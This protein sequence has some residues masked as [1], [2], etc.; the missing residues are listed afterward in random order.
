MTA[1]E[2]PRLNGAELKPFE[3]TLQELRAV[4]TGEIAQ[5]MEQCIKE[6]ILPQDQVALCEDAAQFTL[7]I[8]VLNIARLRGQEVNK[9]TL[10]AAYWRLEKA[11]KKEIPSMILDYARALEAENSQP[12]RT[13][14]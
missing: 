12:E 10:L 13:P 4:Y 2:H 8:M 9:K 7:F 14:E 5:V 11:I 6:L 1:P 3:E